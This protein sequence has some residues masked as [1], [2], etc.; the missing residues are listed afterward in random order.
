MRGLGTGRDLFPR[1]RGQAFGIVRRVLCV[2]ERWAA[3]CN[4]L[5]LFVIGRDEVDSQYPGWQ[6]QYSSYF[7]IR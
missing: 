3:L 6:K 4:G 2:L 5:W 7:G 1:V